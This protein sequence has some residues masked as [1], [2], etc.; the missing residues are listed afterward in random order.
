MEPSEN[1]WNNRY[2]GN[3]IGWD[4]GYVSTPIKE[5][6]DQLVD[7]NIRILIPGAGNSY[8]AEYLHHQGFKHVFVVDIAKTP[9]D[10]FKKRVPDFPSSHLIHADFFDLKMSFDLILEQT[11]FCAIHPKFRVSYVQKTRELLKR[12][13]KLVGLLFDI[14]LQTDGPPFGGYKEEYLE[15]FRKDF[16][17][18]IMQEAYNSIPN[19]LDKELFIK[20]RKK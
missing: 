15:Y 3:N 17:I 7:K 5:Y 9:L 11:F 12:N 20:L 8:E 10:N 4:I 14:P 16:E 6:I 19:R 13:G 1:F 2:I 18:D